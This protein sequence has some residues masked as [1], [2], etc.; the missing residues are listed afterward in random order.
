MQ[1]PFQTRFNIYVGLK[2]QQN[3]CRSDSREGDSSVTLEVLSVL[4]FS[5]HICTV[6]LLKIILNVAGLA[7]S[8]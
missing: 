8:V 7:Q 4:K 1:P 2:Y 6:L 3:V 5:E